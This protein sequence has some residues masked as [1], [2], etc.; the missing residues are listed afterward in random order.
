ITAS[1]AS[2]S[3]INPKR[4]EYQVRLSPLERDW[5]T[6][7][8]R[9]ARYPALPPGSYQ[10]ELRAR[11]GAGGWGPPTQLDFAVL[12]AWRR[13]QWF[14]VLSGA[15]VLAALGGIVTWRQRVLWRRRAQQLH[16]QS[17]ATFRELIEAMPD[18]VSVH[19]D[20]KLTYLNQAARHMLGVGGGRES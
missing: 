16:Q 5:S 18:L 17:D 20:D 1:F 2:D 12:P 4:V 10:L 15:L 13:T 14:I 6:T 19:R 9:E 11:I 7:R 3:F 8:L